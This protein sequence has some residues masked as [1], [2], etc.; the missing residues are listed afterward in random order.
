MEIYEDWTRGYVG[1]A[2]DPGMLIFDGPSDDTPAGIGLDTARLSEANRGPK[3][4][5]DNIYVGV[6]PE[7]GSMAALAMGLSGLVGFAIRRRR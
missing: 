4:L 7:P 2:G 6:I 3:G 1:Y 5:H